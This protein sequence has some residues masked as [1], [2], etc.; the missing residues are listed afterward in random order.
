[1]DLVKHLSGL[2]LTSRDMSKRIKELKKLYPQWKFEAASKISVLEKKASLG[3]LYWVWADFEFVRGS[4]IDAV[5]LNRVPFAILYENM[6]PAEIA[7]WMRK[8]A[9]DCI[10]AGDDERFFLCAERELPPITVSRSVCGSLWGDVDFA[11]LAAS[12]E[13]IVLVIDPAMNVV[14]GN[15]FAAAVFTARSSSYLKGKKL[16]DVIGGIEP[17]LENAVLEAFTYEQPVQSFVFS[18]EF[19]GKKNYYNCSL[20]PQRNDRGDKFL[21]MLAKDVTRQVVAEE[22]SR[23][24]EKYRELRGELW[25][26]EK[27]LSDLTEDELIRILFERIGNKLQMSRVCFLRFNEKEEAYLHYEWLNGAT[28]PSNDTTRIPK[29]IW[30]KLYHLEYL[31]LSPDSIDNLIKLFPI[32][33]PFKAFIRKNFIKD[34]ISNILFFPLQVGSEPEAVITFDWCRDLPKNWSESEIYVGLEAMKILA[35]HIRQKRILNEL[36]IEE[37]RLRIAVDSSEI[38]FCDWNLK[39]RDFYYSDKVYELLGY[40]RGEDV[41]NEKTIKRLL[42]PDDRTNVFYP[43]KDFI[44]GKIPKDEIHFEFRI[45]KRSTEWVWLF[46]QLRA[47]RRDE[48][49][50]QRVIGIMYEISQQKREEE[51]LRKSEKYYLDLLMKLPHAIQQHNLEGKIIF[52]NPAQHR[53]MGY[54]DGELIGRNIFEF[55][56]DPAEVPG[57]REEYRRVIKEHAVPAPFTARIRKKDGTAIVARIEWSYFYDQDGRLMGMTY[58]YTDI[59]AQTTSGEAL[60][61]SEMHLKAIFD[62]AAVGI[63]LLDSGF[64]FVRLNERGGELLGYKPGEAGEACRLTDRLPAA[65]EQYYR[66]KLAK[67]RSG[68]AREFCFEELFERKNGEKFWAQISLSFIGGSRNEPELIVCLIQDADERVKKS[69]ELAKNESRLKSIIDNMTV[70]I[71]VTDLDGYVVEINELGL[72]LLGVSIEEV[73]GTNFMQFFLPE[74]MSFHRERIIRLLE[75]DIFVY[76]FEDWIVSKT[77]RKFWASLSLTLV[78]DENGKPVLASGVMADIDDR[79]KVEQALRESEERLKLALE[80]SNDGLYDWNVRTNEVFLSDRYFTMCGYDPAGM[81]HTVDGTKMIIHPED[82]PLYEKILSDYRKGRIER[83]ELELRQLH[84]EG[85]YVWILS[86]GRVVGKDEKGRNLRVIGTHVDIT[87]LKLIQQRMMAETELLL[88]TIRSIGEGMIATDGA[89]HILIMNSIA[90]KLTGVTASLGVGQ[91]LHKVYHTVSEDD[92]KQVEDPVGKIIQFGRE[93]SFSSQVILIAQDGSER[94]VDQNVSPILDPDGKVFGAVIIFRDI[95]GQKRI[96]EYIRMKDR[97]DAMGVLA[98]SIAHDFN[99]YLT[100]ILG[101]LSIM[102][103]YVKDSSQLSILTDSENAAVIAKQLTQQ[104]MNFSRAGEPVKRIG[105]IEPTLRNTVS[106]CLGNTGITADIDIAPDLMC[107]EFDESQIS[108]A[109]SNIIINAVQAMPSGGT[110]AIAARNAQP[111]EAPEKILP[112]EHYIKLTI[113]DEGIGIPEKYLDKVFDP[114]FTTKDKGT[115]LGLASVYSIVRRHKGYVTVDSSVGNGT[116]FTIYLPALADY[117]KAERKGAKPDVK[118]SGRVLLLDDDE[119]ILTV[120]ARLLTYIGYEVAVVSTIDEAENTFREGASSG[121]KFDAVLLDLNIRGKAGGL[122]ALKRIRKIDPS[123]KAILLTAMTNDPVVKD[124]KKNGFDDLIV[125]PFSLDDLKSSLS[126]LAKK[127]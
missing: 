101:N 54:E 44:L 20:F 121:R 34:G 77:G 69:I 108:Q 57:A 26:L 75:K 4:G 125:K 63:A 68:G 126:K 59:T 43:A 112:E 48:S 10:A 2:F 62:N 81:P 25:E 55:Y 104:L 89:G 90:E 120:G 51:I 21:I 52:S 107:L 37:E 12:A 64:R 50:V 31:E 109:L 42:H 74:R 98:G 33:K 29:P 122:E 3:Q 73:R 95:T 17:S 45:R 116:T 103:Y 5:G 61:V 16:K 71:G 7:D 19:F 78:F 110:I 67:F 70:A 105:S 1:M 72:K 41:F 82:V 49:G 83:H 117:S 106:F 87:P 91:T 97:F 36:K 27:R 100:V 6:T 99:N 96:D 85:Q 30:S 35:S 86:R 13:Y 18:T 127:R 119:M 92:H 22:M 84:K 114:F 88:V 46:I 66:A 39:D 113:K 47:I 40:K 76:N 9:R 115:G 124:Y 32:L 11:C 111:G 14:A 8:G 53:L 60:R 38:G 15:D 79:R 65:K 80:A 118:L 94:Y 93:F 28:P 24:E 56:A 58:V 123:V 23:R 102:K